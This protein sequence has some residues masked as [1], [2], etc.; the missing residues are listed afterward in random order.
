M[1]GGP[2]PPPQPPT[3]GTAEY[4]FVWPENAETIL[5]YL[6]VLGTWTILGW[7]FMR[8]NACLICGRDN[9]LCRH[10]RDKYDSGGNKR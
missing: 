10:T 1:P 6:L 9:G 7:W 8:G 2:A 5:L 3:E 4:V